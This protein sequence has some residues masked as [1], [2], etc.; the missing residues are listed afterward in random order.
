MAPERKNKKGD[1]KNKDLKILMLLSKE[2]LTDDR[3]YREAKALID[4]GHEVTVITWDKYGERKPQESIDG[5]DIVRIGNNK[6]MRFLP[7]NLFR[8]PIWWRLAYKK[9]LELYRDGFDFDVVH[10]HD[11]DTLQAGV[12]LK[13][14]LGIK[15]IYDAHEIFGY[16][17]KDQNPLLSRYSF[18]MEK[19]MLEYVDHIVTIDEP[20]KK[21]YERISNLPVTIVMNCKDLIYSDYEAPN[22]EIFTLV[23]IGLM[24]KG[25]FFPEILEVIGNM[26]GVRLIL[27]GKKEGLFNKIKEMSKKYKNIKF[28]G[29]IP[30]EEILPLTRKS[31]ATFVI[32]DRK[33]QHHMN[34]FN[35]QFEAMVCGRPIIVTR[36]T[37]AGEMTERLRC[38]LTVEYNKE[39]VREAVLILRDNPDLCEELGKNAFKAAKEKY[40]WE[41][42]KKK[43]LKVYE[44]IL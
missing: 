29:T 42:E 39:S 7:N 11:L 14:K 35:K 31:D 4:A 9:G 44:E 22:N 8:N 19:R 17:L 28:L 24:S 18:K 2:I 34:V 16:M 38:G 23:Y 37:Y 5:I 21:Y 13:E 36:G 43:L 33:G 12:W 40:N 10:C 3:V 25:R 32:V 20:F 1:E 30:K 6:L 26:E 15:L 27:A 41:N